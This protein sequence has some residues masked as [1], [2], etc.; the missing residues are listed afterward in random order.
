MSLVSKIRDCG[1]F[2]VV[3]VFAFVVV[4]PLALFVGAISYITS[5]DLE[6][7]NDFVCYKTRTDID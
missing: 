5:K 7:E 6:P 1:V 2:G 4:L 3:T